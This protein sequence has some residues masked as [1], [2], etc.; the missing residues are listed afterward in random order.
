[1]SLSDSE[2]SSAKPSPKPSPIPKSNELINLYKI[3]SDVLKT[4]DKDAL[5]KLR[6]EFTKK[7]SN[8]KDFIIQEINNIYL[9]KENNDER[10]KILDLLNNLK[11]YNS[12]QI[13]Q[14][15]DSFGLTTLRERLLKTIEIMISKAEK[16]KYI[17]YPNYSDKNFYNK[18]FVKNEFYQ[19]LY[20]NL[21]E[22]VDDEQD[23]MA[24]ICNYQDPKDK[25]KKNNKEAQLWKLTSYQIFL[26]NYLNITTPYNGIL[27]FHGLGSGKSCSA[28]TIA[29]T[30]KKT[31][32]S[33][34][35]KI[36]VLV[37]GQAMND[38]FKEQ[39]HNIEKAY[40]QC[41]YS[42]Y[43]NYFPTDSP[44]FKT[45]KSDILI[46]KY[47]DIDHYQKFAN[48]FNKVRKE[49]PDNFKNWIKINYSNRVVI[50][51]EIHNLRLQ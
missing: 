51:D 33:N 9:S 40:N 16:W 24:E 29:E 21:Y 11:N 30:Y 27:L 1:V 14:V 46:N 13:D 23:V 42:E 41:T 39:I 17:S 49:D 3:R 4:T 6:K 43:I 19:N 18:I 37:G 31:F 38:N 15:A 2:K 34:F 45:I 25:K 35:K 12:N 22:D 7:L 36:L 48:R 10:K 26:K 8:Q 5:N 47:Y 50:I 32:S 44:D 28:I 20:E